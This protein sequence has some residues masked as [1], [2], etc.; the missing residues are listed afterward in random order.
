MEPGE[1]PEEAGRGE[2]VVGDDGGGG[3][4][5]VLLLLVGDA[6]VGIVGVGVAPLT[7][8]ATTG[9][10]PLPPRP[11]LPPPLPPPSPITTPTPRAATSLTVRICMRLAASYIPLRVAL[12]PC[13]VAAS[14]RRASSTRSMCASRA[15]SAAALRSCVRLSAAW[16]SERDAQ[17]TTNTTSSACG[18]AHQSMGR[19]RGG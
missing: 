15:S 10:P 5:V 8:A 18:D 13:R 2:R 9:P 6:G 12:I 3:D 4:D 14:F 11:P 1:A 19:R 7:R 16:T 17:P